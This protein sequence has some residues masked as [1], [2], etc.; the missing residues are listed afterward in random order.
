MKKLIIFILLLI[1][2]CYIVSALNVTYVPNTNAFNMTNNCNGLIAIAPTVIYPLTVC[3]HNATEDEIS[4]SC[5]NYTSGN[6]TQ[7]SNFTT[8]DF[9]SSLLSSGQA[10]SI[11][12]KWERIN[13]LNMN[14]SFL[15]GKNDS[16]ESKSAYAYCGDNGEEPQGYTD[17]G[18]SITTSNNAHYVMWANSGCTGTLKSYRNESAGSFRVFEGINMSQYEANVG[19]SASCTLIT[20][21]LGNPQQSNFAYDSAG[22]STPDT[23]FAENIPEYVKLKT[24]TP[25]SISNLTNLSTCLYVGTIGYSN[26]SSLF[27]YN[28]SKNYPLGFSG[29][30]SS[31]GTLAINFPN[32]LNAYN[33][34]TNTSNIKVADSVLLNATWQATANLSAYWLYTDLMG[35]TS[36]VFFG[37]GSTNYS[38]YTISANGTIGQVVSWY[39][40]ANDTNNQ[41]NKST[42][43]YFTIIDNSSAAIIFNTSTSWTYSSA[44]GFTVQTKQFTINNTGNHLAGNCSLNVTGSLNSFISSNFFNISI[45]SSTDEIATISGLSD[46][47]YAGNLY[48]LCQNGGISNAQTNTT[49]FGSSVPVSFSISSPSGSSGGGGGGGSQTQTPSNNTGHFKLQTSFNSASYDFLAFPSQKKTFDMIISNKDKSDNTITFTCASDQNLCSWITLNQSSVTL[50]PNSDYQADV[51][52]QMQIPSMAVKGKYL[53]SLIGQ[54]AY[55]IQTLP[56]TISISNYANLGELFF[57]KLAQSYVLNSGKEGAQPIYIP[58][59]VPLLI[60]LTIFSGFDFL[61][62]PR[63]VKTFLP[64]LLLILVSIVMFIA[65]WLIL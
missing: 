33:L 7:N 12:L 32:L 4:G 57:G 1:S 14:N 31:N 10:Y 42:T 52:I 45:A 22:V 38:N 51:R 58:K 9:N 36:A 60:V 50:P 24:C 19:A 61:I 41:I 48:A 39:F 20:G 47:T 34:T 29:M 49:Q 62:L 30:I 16:G 28:G 59:V 13:Y 21:S 40:W 17:A 46:G 23:C 43:K 44:N 35:N 27:T 6:F 3:L 25:T 63:F 2:S 5:I 56:V 26:S 53:M 37:G 65:V 64:Q 15:N 18:C 11:N 55:G 8:N 54:D